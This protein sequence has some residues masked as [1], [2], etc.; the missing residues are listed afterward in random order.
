MLSKKIVPFVVTGG[1]SWTFQTL[2]LVVFKTKQEILFIL[3][4]INLCA[5]IA[6]TC[7]SLDN[8]LHLNMSMV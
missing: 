5:D 2:N 1:R 6:E 3:T 8:F 4:S 7:G